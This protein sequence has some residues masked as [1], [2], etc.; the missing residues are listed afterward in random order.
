MSTAMDAPGSVWPGSVA[1][2]ESGMMAAPSDPSAE[3][4]WGHGANATTMATS[5]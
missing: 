2:D 3:S 4:A 5:G 1:T